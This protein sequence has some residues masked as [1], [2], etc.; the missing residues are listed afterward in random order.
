M[1]RKSPLRGI[2]L[3]FVGLVMV[4]GLI[5]LIISLLANPSEKATEVVDQFYKYE[6]DG[7][8]SES[9][10]LFHSSM[11]ERFEMEYY[12]QDRARMLMNDFGV[13]TFT[14]KISKPEKVKDWQMEK[15]SQPFETVFKV[16]VIQ[17][18]NSRYGKFSIFQEV[19]VVKE[20]KQ[21]KVLW[22]YQY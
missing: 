20:E 11:Q 14:Y 8:F 2:V 7:D 10:S 17:N 19:F 4:T 18:F 1:Y 12:I 22:D 21:W 13:E 16:K 15:D 3:I 5:W 9:W 6:Q